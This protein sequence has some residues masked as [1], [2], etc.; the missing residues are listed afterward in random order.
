MFLRKA[1]V[2][3]HI[4]SNDSRTNK[5]E[6]FEIIAKTLPSILMQLKNINTLKDP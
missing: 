1:K 4:Y 5:T 2:T 6:T 3:K